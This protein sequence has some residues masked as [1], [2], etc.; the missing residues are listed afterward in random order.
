MHL[1]KVVNVLQGTIR[2]L[3]IVLDAIRENKK[4]NNNKKE[5]FGGFINGE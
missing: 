2:G 4:H 5:I 1:Y 3:A